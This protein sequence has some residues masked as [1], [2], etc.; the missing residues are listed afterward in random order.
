MNFSVRPSENV[1]SALKVLR[2]ITDS[3]LDFKFDSKIISTVSKL[4]LIDLNQALFRCSEEDLEDGTGTYNV[5]GYG[6]L[7]YCGLQGIK[8]IVES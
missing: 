5:P 3:F 2:E 4:N 6:N 7:V 1:Q 8:T